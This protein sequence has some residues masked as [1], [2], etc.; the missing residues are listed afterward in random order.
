MHVILM[1][2]MT[3][4]PIGVM[5]TLGHGSGKLNRDLVPTDDQQIAGVR[6]RSKNVSQSVVRVQTFG[7]LTRTKSRFAKRTPRKYRYLRASISIIRCVFAHPKVAFPR[8]PQDRPKGLQEAPRWLQ[9]APKR[10]PRGPKM[11]PRSPQG[12]PRG[13]QGVSKGPQDEPR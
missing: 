13:L 11:V 5:G 3:L 6:T 12:A 8:D 9:G 1:V 4:G 7:G 10:V 2:T